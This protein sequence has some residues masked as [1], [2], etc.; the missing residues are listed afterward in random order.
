MEIGFEHM[1]L[2]NAILKA[3]FLTPAVSARDKDARKTRMA[4]G[5]FRFAPIT[6]DVLV[7][8]RT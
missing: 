6:G 4:R 8:P 5:A 2:A 3:E 1:H 7:G